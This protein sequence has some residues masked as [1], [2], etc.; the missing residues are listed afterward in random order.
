MLGAGMEHW[1]VR[2]IVLRLSQKIARKVV[3]KQPQKIVDLS[4]PQ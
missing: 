2:E 1:I 3:A 4:L